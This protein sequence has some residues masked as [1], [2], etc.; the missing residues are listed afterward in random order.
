MNTISEP[1]PTAG[2]RR[3]ES[4]CAIRASMRRSSSAATRPARRGPPRFSSST[5]RVTSTRCP[6]S[7][8]RARLPLPS[9]LSPLPTGGRL[10]RGRVRAHRAA[11]GDAVARGGRTAPAGRRCDIRGARPS[12]RREARL[13]PCESPARCEQ[14]SLGPPVHHGRDLSRYE[15]RQAAFH[16]WVARPE[17]ATEVT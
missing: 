16:V 6:G 7:L 14:G 15:V 4:T 10:Y 5:A 3:W 17:S 1:K 8:R 12:G 11:T 9:S 13:L 2:T